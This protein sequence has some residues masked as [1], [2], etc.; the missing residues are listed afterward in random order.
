MCH[1]SSTVKVWNIWRP[2]CLDFSRPCLSFTSSECGLVLTQ[3]TGAF[4]TEDY[5]K[6][7]PGSSVKCP[8]CELPDSR[9]H[10]LDDC[11]ATAPLRRVFPALFN[12]W[13]ELAPHEKYFGLFGELTGI[14]EFRAAVGSVTFPELPRG[15]PKEDLVI[16]T[17]GSCMFPRIPQLADF[18]VCCYLCSSGWEFPGIGSWHCPWRMSFCFSGRGYGARQRCAFPEDWC[19]LLW[20]LVCGACGKWSFYGCSAMVVAPSYPR[21]ILTCGLGFWKVRVAVS[22]LKFRS[23][24]SKVMSAGVRP[25]AFRGSMHGSTTWADRTAGAA[26]HWITCL[27]V[28]QNFIQRFFRQRRI[29][30]WVHEYQTRVAFVFASTDTVEVHVPVEV[31]PGEGVGPFFSVSD[32]RIEDCAVTH[33]GF[34][35]KLVSWLSSLKWYTGS[36]DREVCDLSWLGLFWGFIHD[37]H[38]LPPF[39]Y[40]GRW[41][42]MDDDVAYGF[43]LP[44]VKVLF[45]TW[46][47]CVDALVRGGMLVPWGAVPSTASTVRLGARFV[48]PGI[49]GF[50]AL[51]HI[52]LVDLSFQFAKSRCLA[53]LRIPSFY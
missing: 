20:L 7:I 31:V 4:F 38:V 42:T 32:V 48:C 53:D 47:C 15:D 21:N 28:Y 19:S 50:V 36:V 49:S 35:R 8:K 13:N 12:V 41:V 18:V 11:V 44:S 33:T 5:R 29:A 2:I 14:K 52:A 3:Q 16:F 43:V 1:G 34:A 10:R 6:H 24:G 37:T 9:E 40:G 22:L 51:S 26:T 46:R 17:D 30:R 25:L 45:R 23:V 27:P 39:R